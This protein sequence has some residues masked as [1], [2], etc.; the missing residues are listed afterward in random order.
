M[1]I[2][3]IVVNT[4]AIV[5][6]HPNLRLGYGALMFASG[7]YLSYRAMRSLLTDERVCDLGARALTIL[8]TVTQTTLF[9][10]FVQRGLSKIHDGIEALM[11]WYI[12]VSQGQLRDVQDII[13]EANHMPRQRQSTLVRAIVAQLRVLVTPVVPQDE[14]GILLVYR[15]VSSILGDMCEADDLRYV[16]AATML[17]IIVA[18][19]FR[20]D[21]VQRVCAFD[22][23]M[24]DIARGLVI[25]RDLNQH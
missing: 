23:L 20:R 12:G 14:A 7:T 15:R 6:R 1:D 19:Y 18:T 25:P 2:H 5:K 22:L 10:R 13:Y 4:E 11:A 9:P 3:K 21:D 8:D 16:D 17:P 24:P